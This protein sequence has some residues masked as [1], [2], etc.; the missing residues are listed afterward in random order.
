[1]LERLARWCHRERKVVVVA[2][3]N[4]LVLV[5]GCAAAFGGALSSSFEVPASESQRALELLFDRFPEQAGAGAEVVFRA[6]ATV[7]D[8]AVVSR[9]ER[10][11]AELEKTPGVGGVVSPYEG[12]AGAF[13]I[14]ED[15]RIAFARVQF[16]TTTLDIPE[17]TVAKIVRSVAE[18]NAE[19]LQ[20]EVGG[21]A[22]QFASTADSGGTRDAIGL[23]AAVVVLLFTFGSVVAMGLPIVTALFGLGVALTGVPLISLVIDVPIFGPSLAVMIGLGVGIDYALF[24]LTRFRACLH[25]GESSEDACATALTTSGRAVL[26]AGVTV[27]I[28][29]LGLFIMG[30]SFVYG[31]AVCAILAV[32]VTMLASVTLLPALLGFAGPAVD[33]LAIPGLGA[34]KPAGRDS[35]WHRWSRFVQRHPWPAA[36]GSLALL[37]VL[38]SPVLS[39]RLGSTDAG[40]NPKGSTTREA[41]DLIS[42][43]FGPGFNG[44]LLL[45]AE[46]DGPEDLEALGRLSAAVGSQPGVRFAAPPLTNQAGDA[47]IVL[48]VPSTAPQA[49]ETG[50]LIERL[51]GAVVPAA[52]AGSG[53]QV[54]VGG[55]TAIYNDLGDILSERLPIFMGVVIGLSFLL[56]LVVFRSVLV[57][58]KAAFMNLLSIG[59]SYGVIVAVFQWGWGNELI[60]V[61]GT[62]PIQS[63]APMMLFAILFGLSMDYEVFL[64][65]RMREEYLRTGDNAVAVADGLASTARVITAAAA[66]MITVFASFVFNPDAILKLFGLGLATAILM[67]ATIVRTVLV[68]ATMELLGDR[69]WWFPDWLDRIVPEVDVESDRLRGDASRAVPT[70]S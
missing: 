39:M 46:I 65:S 36:L 56:L 10:L 1:V 68:P 51:R 32:L 35:G 63:F 18:A 2:W 26:F 64:I 8:P 17:G 62:G 13:Q 28:S 27:C 47:A 34:R 16:A 4:S 43:G 67:D 29:M 42:E 59:A 60:G 69:N 37:L 33:R 41:Y 20:V 57:P 21:Q 5:A 45:A 24:I 48:V 66:I 52:L 22:V 53:L 14:S 44:P 15:R 54:N 9:M 7:D 6:E 11:F 50:E 55:V 3:L 61:G 25:A 40:S 12:A 70:Q 23:F 38:A 19:D 49:V 58:I 31:M 30:I